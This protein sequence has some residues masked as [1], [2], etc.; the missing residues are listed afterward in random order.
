MNPTEIRWKTQKHMTLKEQ[1]G[2][3][4]LEFPSFDIAGE[5]VHGFS[6]RL[7]GVS[8]GFLS[9]MNFSRALGD[10]EE[11]IRE[12][13]RRIG[14]AIGFSPEDMVLSSQ[15][16]TANV[17]VVTEEDKG[18]GYA[19]PRDYTDVDGLVTNVPGLVLATSFADCVPL[20][21]ID[22]V[23]KAIGLSHSG[24]KGTVRKIGLRTVE[25]MQT[26]FQTDPRDLIAGIGP[27]ICQDCYEVNED[28]IQEFR[29]A[30]PE[31]AWNDLFYIKENGHYQLSLWEANRRIFLEAG[32]PDSRI[33]LPG[34]CTACNPGFLFSHR[35]SHG[36]RGNMAAFLGI[37]AVSRL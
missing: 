12:N 6:T 13:F 3:F 29:E 28:V 23:H 7:G 1:D 5:Y 10:T 32:I 37:R 14:K 4:W 26:A 19:K 22:P 18:C 31:E 36:K 2:V 11:N 15:T 27:S 24:W 17:R 35:A 33:S 34:I 30:F 20:F 21:L 8:S 9:S 25:L 16:H